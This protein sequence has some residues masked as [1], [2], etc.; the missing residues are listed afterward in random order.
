MD[1]IKIHF[2][3]GIR[4]ECLVFTII[5]SFL[6]EILFLNIVTKKRNCLLQNWIYDKRN[7]INKTCTDASIP[8]N[9]KQLF[10]TAFKQT[11]SIG[12]ISRLSL[13][14]DKTKG[15]LFGYLKGPVKTVHGTKMNFDCTKVLGT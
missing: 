14:I 9:G 10:T 8:L 1:Y 13:N 2:E 3:R 6:T 15:M 5:L 4:Q 11:T 12:T 7:N